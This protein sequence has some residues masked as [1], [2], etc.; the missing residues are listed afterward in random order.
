MTF[1]E[2]KEKLKHIHGLKVKAKE[3]AA[4]INECQLNIDALTLHSGLS[5]AL[6]IDGGRSDSVVERIVVKIEQRQ[7]QLVKLL[8]NIMREEDALASSIQVLSELEQDVIVGYYLRDKSHGR[9][10]RE[11]HYSEGH[12]KYLKHKALEKIANKI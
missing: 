7:E 4:D 1:E 8:D 10:A 12:I 2:A 6:Q 5:G 3:I 9:L 11:L